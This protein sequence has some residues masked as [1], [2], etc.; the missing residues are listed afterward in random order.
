MLSDGPVACVDK[1]LRCQVEHALG[2]GGG[3]RLPNVSCQPLPNHPEKPFD[4]GE[5]SAGLLHLFVRGV[6]LEDRLVGRL[7]VTEALF[8]S[9]FRWNLRLKSSAGRWINLPRSPDCAAV[10]SSRSKGRPF[11]DDGR[12]NATDKRAWLGAA[13]RRTRPD[14]ACVLCAGLE[15]VGRLGHGSLK[16]KAVGNGNAP[17][18][19]GLGDHSPTEPTIGSAAFF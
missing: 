16:V 17:V 10:A 14:C 13:R 5:F 9:I 19:Y 15:E 2:L 11:P 8:L 4:V 12:L 1:Q 18:G 3:A 7:K 6:L